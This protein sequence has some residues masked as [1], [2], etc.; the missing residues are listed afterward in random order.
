MKESLPKLLFLIVIFFNKVEI[1]SRGAIQPFMP[2]SVYSGSAS[3]DDW[4]QAFL[5][6]FRVSSCPLIGSHTMPG[7]KSQ[8]TSAL[9][10][11][12]CF[13]L[14]YNLH[15]SKN[16]R[17]LL[18]ATAV[19]WGMERTAKKSQHRKLT[20]EKKIIPPF[21]PVFELATFGQLSYYDPLHVG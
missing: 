20:L 12:G 14:R 3:S 1:S 18:R 4:S 21:L 6:D 16:G 11:Q 19:T 9:L 10:G 5:D 15:F 17:G 2:G 7:L 8:P 13:I